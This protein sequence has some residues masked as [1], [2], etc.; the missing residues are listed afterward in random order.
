MGILFN[1]L[2]YVLS[3]SATVHSTNLFCSHDN[4]TIYRTV[5]CA[6]GRPLISLKLWLWLSAVLHYSLMVIWLTALHW[7]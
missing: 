4:S 3:A 2:I 7:E 5:W 1:T 6:D